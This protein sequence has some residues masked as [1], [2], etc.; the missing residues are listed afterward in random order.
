MISMICHLGIIALTTGIVF[1]IA[2]TITLPVAH[3]ITPKSYSIQ[4]DYLRIQF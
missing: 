1:T 3:A 2:C 4:C